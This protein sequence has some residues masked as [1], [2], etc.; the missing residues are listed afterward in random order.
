MRHELGWLLALAHCL[1]RLHCFSLLWFLL[2]CFDCYF[3]SECLIPPRLWSAM[4]ESES[5]SYVT[6]DGQSVSLSWNK[7]PIWGLRPD[8]YYCQ[9]VSGFLMWGAVSDERTGLSFTI[10]ADPRQRSHFRVRVP[11][12]LWLYFT[13]SDLRL[14]FSSPPTTRRATVDVFDPA[15]TRGCH[16]WN[17]V[18]PE[19]GVWRTD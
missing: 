16:V 5:E 19:V 10:A 13:V 2:C 12:D 9:T 11:W 4:S 17:A 3:W 14:P 7:A 15:S 18:S 6:T 8:F 1:L